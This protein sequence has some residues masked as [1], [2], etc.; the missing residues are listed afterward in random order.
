MT[1]FID[2]IKARLRREPSTEERRVAPRFTTHLEQRLVVNVSL[3]EGRK[4]P[5]NVRLKSVLAG[6]T[7][8][9][10][11]TGLGIIVPDIRIGGL[12]ITRPDRL[13]R[14]VLGLPRHPVEIQAVPVRYV[15]LEEVE[16]GRYLIGMLIKSMSEQDRKH[17]DAFLKS[18]L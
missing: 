7:R 12:N 17:Y 11:E 4:M 9:V 15:E 18:L 8:D 5:G 6:Y 13:L 14:I 3:L 10:S 2:Y 16:H 1:G